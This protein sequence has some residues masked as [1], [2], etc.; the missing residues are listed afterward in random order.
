MAGV[1]LWGSILWLAPILYAVLRNETKF[2][3][4]LAVGVT[5]S[6][7]GPAGPP[8]DGPAPAFSPG[9]WAGSAAAFLRWGY[10]ACSSG[11]S[12]CPFACGAC[13]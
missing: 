2:K 13:G 12:P 10:P 4:N 7:P 5:F 11:V 1:I 3:K 8:G 6:L 9:S